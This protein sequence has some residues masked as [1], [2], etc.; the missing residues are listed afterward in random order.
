M[1]SGGKEMTGGYALVRGRRR[2]VALMASAP[3]VLGV[4]AS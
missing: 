4:G 1:E 3:A 2:A